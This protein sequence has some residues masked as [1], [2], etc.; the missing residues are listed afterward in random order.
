VQ[1]AYEI[2]SCIGSGEDGEL[3]N[4]QEKEKFGE[5]DLNNNERRKELSA[6]ALRTAGTESMD[7]AD[8]VLSASAKESLILENI[9][10]D[11]PA[12]QGE[13]D[14]ALESLG[15]AS[16]QIENTATVLE[17]LALDDHKMQDGDSYTADESTC[18]VAGSTPL[19]Y[20]IELEAIQVDLTHEKKVLSPIR[21]DID[22][23]STLDITLPQTLHTPKTDLPDLKID[24][25]NED[26][27]NLDIAS[28]KTWTVMKEESDDWEDAFA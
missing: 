21:D 19:I 3:V 15:G 13:K 11:T 22:E 16:T 26:D 9:N 17:S 6:S 5:T 18:Q 25:G 2:T 8:G 27:D 14:M 28:G 7:T 10:H 20:D 23:P 4:A 24:A 1:E 12:P